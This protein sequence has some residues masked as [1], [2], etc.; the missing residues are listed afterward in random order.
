MSKTVT[1]VCFT[2]NNYTNAH[3]EDLKT[4]GVELCKYIVIGKE[5]GESG[6][7]HLQGFLIL[8]KKTKIKTVT[9]WIKGHTEPARGKNEEAANYCKKDGVFFEH[10]TY[11]KGKGARTDIAEFL[12]AVKRGADDL[13]LAEEHPDCY[14]KYQRAKENLRTV[15]KKK[16]NFAKMQE[17]YNGASLRP[18]QKITLKKLMEQDNRKVTWVYDADGNIGKSWLANW[19]YVNHG[20]YII[21]GGK[22]ADVS[23]AYNCEEIVVFDFTRSQE[24]QVNYSLIESFKNGRIFSSKYESSLK[25]FTPAKV[26]CLS[27]F[28][29]DREKLSADRWQVLEYTGIEPAR[30][31]RRI[32]STL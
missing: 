20:A 17:E 5:T 3:Y 24:E 29:P 23:Y 30:K 8:K 32:D 11:P 10:G 2:V 1:R 25:V 27:N 12:D 18:W 13:V 26:L 16:R 9:G 15:S 28:N 6:T 22:R 31:R 7:P 21:E 14:A 19:L 4:K